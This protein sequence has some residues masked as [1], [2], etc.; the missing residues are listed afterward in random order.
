[1]FARRSLVSE[2]GVEGGAELV[3]ELLSE[4]DESRDKLDF[5]AQVEEIALFGQ[6]SGLQGDPEALKN[7]LA[8]LELA[9]VLGRSGNQYSHQV[10]LQRQLILADDTKS[11][12]QAEL[13][14]AS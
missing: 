4:G 14:A 8:R 12:L 5:Y 7:S 10:P 1:M 6:K 11:L 3:V 2:R 9:F 13:R